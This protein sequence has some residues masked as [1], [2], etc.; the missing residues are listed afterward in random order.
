[1]LEQVDGLMQRYL[2]GPH[3]AIGIIVG[4]LILLV[5]ANLIAA[6]IRE[7]RRSP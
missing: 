2:E 3:W 6:F 7:V 1:M 4:L 5:L